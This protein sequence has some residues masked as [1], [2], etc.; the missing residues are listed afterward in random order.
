MTKTQEDYRELADRI[1]AD[2]QE[3][4]FLYSLNEIPAEQF[5]AFMLGQSAYWDQWLKAGLKY[6]HILFFTMILFGKVFERVDRQALLRAISA[7]LEMREIIDSND[8]VTIAQAVKQQQGKT[9]GRRWFN[10]FGK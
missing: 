8:G 3:T 7:L 5:E 9:G 10:L 4:G 2:E 6:A 1:L